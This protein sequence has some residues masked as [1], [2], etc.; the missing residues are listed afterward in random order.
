MTE[1]NLIESQLL[2][3]CCGL[4]C[5]G[6]LFD[7]VPLDVS[8][9]I[10]RLSSAGVHIQPQQHFEQ[11][12]GAYWPGRCTVYHNRPQKCRIYR[13]KLLQQFSNQEI[14]RSQAQEII[15]RLV[16]MRD[17]MAQQLEDVLSESEAKPFSAVPCGV[18]S[19]FRRFLQLMDAADATAFRQ[20]HGGLLL[21]YGFLQAQLKRYLDDSLSKI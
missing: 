7:T 19:L 5:D 9:T 20:Q 8:D 16:Q 12:C 2:C 18:R 6:T 10:K 21:N 13:C 4:C 14:N 3:S 1:L 11:P 15:G 17:Q